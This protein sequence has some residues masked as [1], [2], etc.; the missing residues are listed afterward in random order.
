MRRGRRG[1]L[2]EFPHFCSVYRVDKVT[3]VSRKH[4]EG[5]RLQC[6]ALDE[7]LQGGTCTQSHARD[8]GRC[9]SVVG[10]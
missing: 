9:M 6:A 8:R 4:I 3:V 2:A 1:W 7:P 10:S 5:S